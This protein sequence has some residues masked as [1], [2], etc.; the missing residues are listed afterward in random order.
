MGIHDIG[1]RDPKY[2]DVLLTDVDYD[3]L[4][5]EIAEVVA[6]AGGQGRGQ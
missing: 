4:K 5:H 6:F 3:K 2:C 1:G